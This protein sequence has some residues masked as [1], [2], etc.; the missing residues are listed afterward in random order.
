MT[1]SKRV[2]VTG[3]SLGVSVA[4]MALLGACTSM[5]NQGVQDAIHAGTKPY[6]EAY[7]EYLGPASRWLGP[8]NWVIHVN[9]RELAHAEVTVTP[10]WGGAPVKEEVVPAKLAKEET[11]HKGQPERHAASVPGL[12]GPALREQIGA[13]ATSVQ[14]AGEAPFQGCLNPI[15]I[16]M[17]REDGA[18][19]ER[20]GCRGSTG[21]S[22][23][24]SQAVSGFMAAKYGK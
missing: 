14:N 21:W 4:V 16:R 9:T 24:I 7:V 8:A 20:Q 1:Q 5:Q 13:L 3:A 23:T 11:E 17:I 18:L 15:R 2:F 6:V 19:L 10:E 12:S 22:R